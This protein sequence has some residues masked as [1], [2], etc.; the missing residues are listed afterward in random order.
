MKVSVIIPT[1]NRAVLVQEA[2]ESVL[3]QTF[4]DYEI[5]LID[6][7]STDGTREALDRF[8]SNICYIRQENR[9]LSAARNRA[10]E[11]AKGEYIALL[12]SDDFW[13]PHKLALEVSILDRYR[14]VG[15]VFGDFYITT[16]DGENRPNGLYNWFA[17]RPEWREIFSSW[18]EIDVSAEPGMQLSGL[19]SVAAYFG[20]IY[21]TS[22][23]GPRVSPCAAM[24]RKSAIGNWLRFREDDQ[25]CGDWEFFARLSHKSGAAFIAAETAFTRSHEDAVRLTHSDLRPQLEKR[26]EMIDRIW[27]ADTEFYS[28]YK[29][30]VDEVAGRLWGTLMKLYLKV[31]RRER[32]RFAAQRMRG[33]LGAI[34]GIQWKFFLILA[35][36]PG[37]QHLIEAFQW[38][39]ARLAPGKSQ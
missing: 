16:I 33:F 19:K 30:D 28:Q 24:F 29:S 39:R 20:D 23:F 5:I 8:A 32:A 35:Y 11:L 26:V 21:H 25:F 4:D 31:G 37:S 22:L 18:T 7:G 17:T 13:P 38:A 14:D 15:F 12:D 9:G 27:I 10:L 2:I 3:G 1:Y 6:D 34:P 36:I